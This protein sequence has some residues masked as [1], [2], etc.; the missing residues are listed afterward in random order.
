MNTIKKLL[1]KWARNGVSSYVG[2][3]R[4]EERM[5]QFGDFAVW[6]HLYHVGRSVAAK[7]GPCRKYSSQKCI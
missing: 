6:N 5:W 2:M 1:T 7:G 3:H 4:K